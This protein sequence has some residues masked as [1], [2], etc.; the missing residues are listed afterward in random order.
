MREERTKG[1][2]ERDVRTRGC[3][4]ERIINETQEKKTEH[5]QQ[6]IIGGKLGDK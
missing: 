5:M 4:E 6:A 1:E 2:R 3:R